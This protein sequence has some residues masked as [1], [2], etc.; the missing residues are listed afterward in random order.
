MTRRKQRDEV[1]YYRSVCKQAVEAYRADSCDALTLARRIAPAWSCKE[2]LDSC[3]TGDLTIG[4][5]LARSVLSEV[6]LSAADA[7][8]IAAQIV[9]VVSRGLLESERL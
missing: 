8:R 3:N 5:E 1:N 7:R 6:D 2:F 4:V 9:V